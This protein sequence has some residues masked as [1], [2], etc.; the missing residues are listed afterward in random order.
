MKIIRV[1]GSLLAEHEILIDFCFFLQNRT[2]E[3]ILLVPGGGIY[4]RRVKRH[5]G[6]AGLSESQ[7]HWMA[8]KST[9]IMGVLL[10]EL[11]AKA[12][13]T[14]IPKLVPPNNVEVI[15]P[16]SYLKHYNHLPHSWK[17]T[18]DS[19]AVRVAQGLGI[20][21]VIKVTGGSES[22]NLAVDPIA[23]GF[24]DK[25]GM[26]WRIIS[27]RTGKFLERLKDALK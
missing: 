27:A 13:W 5:Q 6:V 24:G 21:L 11:I 18:S 8:I 19:I 7:A 10:C 22:L 4:S 3:G 25:L 23:R 9:E 14:T 12:T 20:E 26:K 15:F 2:G 16:Y 1:G 17:A